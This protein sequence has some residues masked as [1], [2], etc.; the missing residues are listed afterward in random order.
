MPDISFNSESQSRRE[1]LVAIWSRSALDQSGTNSLVLSLVSGA[2]I[3]TLKITW[4][5]NSPS[6]VTPKTSS[7]DVLRHI[8]RVVFAMPVL[9]FLCVG[10]STC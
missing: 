8:S 10:K 5:L 1:R 7:G 3:S 4:S 6:L 9:G 2:I